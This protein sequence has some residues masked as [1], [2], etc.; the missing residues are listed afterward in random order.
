MNDDFVS[1][2]WRR[3]ERFFGSS[4]GKFFSALAIFMAQIQLAL[5]D[6]VGMG[7]FNVPIQVI[8]VS[9]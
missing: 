5:K 6:S 4:R 2:L 7:L 1:G 9:K 8:L 3:T